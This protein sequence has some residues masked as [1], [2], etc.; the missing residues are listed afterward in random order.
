VIECVRERERK[1][2]FIVSRVLPQAGALTICVFV[3]KHVPVII[4]QH[5]IPSM[6]VYK[7]KIFSSL[8]SHSLRQSSATKKKSKLPSALT[9]SLGSFYFI[10]FFFFCVLSL[11][12]SI[13]WTWS[14]SS[15]I[16]IFT[17]DNRLTMTIFSF[18]FDQKKT[19]MLETWKGKAKVM[20]ACKIL[21]EDFLS[22]R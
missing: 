13:V 2:S 21:D 22:I 4:V 6:T 15:K 19:K 14:F 18:A 7:N 1:H 10:L 11:L 17:I 16:E 12:L 8:L 3:Y 9:C 5:F 20:D